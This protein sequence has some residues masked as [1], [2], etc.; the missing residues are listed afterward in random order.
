M[1]PLR[2]PTG[3]RERLLLWLLA[4]LAA[5]LAASIVFD[6]RL[7]RETADAA[8]DHSLA[9]ATL[10]I[11]SHIKAS[12]QSAQL[13]LSAEAEE[14]LRSDATE[15]IYFA[16]RNPRGELLAGDADLPALAASDSDRPRFVDARY[17]GSPIRLAILAVRSAGD[18]LI[19]TVA[20][21]MKKRD[22]ASRRIL[23]AM[24]VPNLSLM[25][26]TV[27]VIYFGVRRGLAPLDDI[28]REIARRS[29][30]DLQPLAVDAAPREVQPMLARLNLLFELLR[31]AAAAQQR[32]LA[33]AAHQ[34]RT[35]LAGLQ[36]QIELVAAEG[37]FSEHGDRLAR[38]NEATDRINHLV[39][40]LLT[41]AR[42]E[43][44]TTATQSFQEVPLHDLVEESA[45]IFIDRALARNIDL[46]FDIAPAHCEGI[47][48][49]LREALGNLIDNA[50]RY[51]P[52]GGSVTVSSGVR[53]GRP[54]LAVEDNGPG[55][56]ETERGRVCDRFYRIPGASGDGCGLGLA[57]VR[58]IAQL[59]SGELELA[60]ADGG[61][62]RIALSFPAVAA[63]PA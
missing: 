60:E 11:A 48:W 34:L 22:R 26:A 58:E 1:R 56:P 36:T 30:R 45:S 23:A 4:P 37:Q 20:E 14:M 59:H 5:I 8:Y 10:D 27:L 55:I 40:Q 21:T 46:G 53:G 51:T 12:G 43:P 47:R 41:F 49:M 32:F 63:R 18:R 7:A 2:P 54:F 44:S 6:Y 33:D 3:L 52:A 19:V 62:L 15:R 25:V 13:V 42:A 9:D 24:V 28:E 50:L 61:G 39:T 35:P 17:H 31:E 57:I 29:P 16:V 38:I